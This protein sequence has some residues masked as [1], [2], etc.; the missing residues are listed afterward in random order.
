MAWNNIIKSGID[1]YLNNEKAKEVLLDSEREAVGINTSI[2]HIKMLRNNHPAFFNSVDY[3]W[4]FNPDA[5]WFATDANWQARALQQMACHWD[6][7]LSHGLEVEPS[8]KVVLRKT[9]VCRFDLATPSYLSREKFHFILI[10]SGFHE[11]SFLLLTTLADL[12]RNKMSHSDEDGWHSIFKETTLN[13][14]EPPYRLIEAISRTI[15]DTAKD[16]NPFSSDA[17]NKIA[18]KVAY[19]RPTEE[20]L[21]NTTLPTFVHDAFYA[22][23]DY[24]ISHELGHR[25]NEDC[26]I[27]MLKHPE[28]F[29]EQEKR[30]DRKGFELFAS[31]WG[32]RSE[33]LDAAP[34]DEPGR[35]LFGPLVFFLFS[36]LRWSLLH[37]VLCKRLDTVSSPELAD[38]LKREIE[39]FGIERK[40]AFAMTNLFK[41]YAAYIAKRGYKLSLNDAERLTTFATIGKMLSEIIS[42]VIQ[43]IP[44]KE[45]IEAC[46][47]AEKLSPDF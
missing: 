33:I 6:G 40:R 21:E 31:S 15:A 44:N 25:L 45:F 38:R 1:P 14:S 23:A 7:C 28:L 10:P 36:S 29:L 37:G 39:A 20:S 11:V 32:Y 13:E 42:K 17:S 9:F 12:T 4:A 3:N 22:L 8:S 5:Y 16:W 19:F 41:P 27:D 2:N 30:A 46:R 35:I 18:Q 34:L 26:P 43:S 47:I 24:A